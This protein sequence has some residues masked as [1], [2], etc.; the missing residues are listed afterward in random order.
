MDSLT[1]GTDRRRAALIVNT[2]SRSGERAFFRALDRLQELGVTLGPTYAVRD[3]VRLPETVRDILEDGSEY[4]VLIL[5]GGDGS[6]S[7]VVDFLAHRD[8]TLGLLP[9]GTA[10]DFAR[11]LEIPVDIEQ[12]CQTIA[13]GKVVDVDLGL[14][15]D[16]YY[17]NVASTG[18]SVKVTQ[19]LSSRLKK[20]GALA[21]PM[22][23]IRA[24]FEHEPFSARLTFPDGDQ[25]PVEYGRLLHL[26]VGNGRF[27]GGGIVVA[28]EASIDDRRL[29]V[30]AIE[31]GRP[32]TL[33]GVARYLK[34]ADFIRMEGVHHHRTERVRLETDPELPINIDGEVVTSTPQDF[35]VDHNAL[36]VIVPR[37][38]A[39]ARQ[40][41]AG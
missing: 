1:D 16:N 26:A 21:Y 25:E 20:I 39:A 7:S 3:P 33:L 15:R 36:K 4:R 28:P 23:A 27:Y 11:T 13:H 35:A 30:L 31:L 9:L 5:G 6:V 32:R 8:V 34:S 17:V 18:L 37:E 10:N 22:A 29:D 12:A 24:F 38:S 2:R 19:A 40:D 41:L 14:A